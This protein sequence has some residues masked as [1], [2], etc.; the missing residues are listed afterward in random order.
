MTTLSFQQHLRS[1]RSSSATA[2]DGTP[3][4]H[5]HV[6]TF[7]N[8]V[9]I[10]FRTPQ[11]KLQTFGLFSVVTMSPAVDKPTRHRRV[12]WA[13]GQEEG[14]ISDQEA[15]QLHAIF[16]GAFGRWWSWDEGEHIQMASKDRLKASVLSMEALDRL[17][18]SVPA[19]A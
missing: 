14:C 6:L 3:A 7:T 5:S 2:Q 15:S 11:Y 8:R 13:K 10:S 4:Q 9:S 17:K 19:R 16:I 1:L 12:D 18:A